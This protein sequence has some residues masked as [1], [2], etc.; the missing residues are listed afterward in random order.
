MVEAMQLGLRGSGTRKPHHF[1]QD[2]GFG[3]RKATVHTSMETNQ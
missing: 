1:A 2:G 3:G